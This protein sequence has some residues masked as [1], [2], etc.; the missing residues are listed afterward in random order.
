MA[1][2]RERYEPTARLAAMASGVDPDIFVRQITQESGW[3]SEVIHCARSSSAGAMGIAQIVPRFHP[4]VNPCSPE[5]ALAYAAGLMRSHLAV[6]DGDYALALSAYNAGPGATASGVKGQLPGWPYAETVNYVSSILNIS[7]DEAR[8]RLTGGSAVPT[9]LPYNP[10]APID[11]QPND[12]SCALQS[13][14]FLLRSIGRAPDASNPTTDPWLTSQLVPGIISPAV[15]LKD[16]TGHPLA[17]WITREYGSEMGFTAH[18]VDVTFDDVA[19]GAGVNPTIMGGRAYNHW[20]GVRR[21]NPD[22]T[23]ALANPA[24]GFKGITDSMSRAQFDALGPFSAVYIDRMP[25]APAP[26][27]P[28]PPSRVTVLVGEIRERLDELERIAS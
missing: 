8:R 11:I 24:P 14:Q 3:L 26:P 5:D 1:S 13:T 20:V 25:A 18:A 4:N 23:L 16:A 15:G 6:W 27:V 17:A 19:A 2:E 7:Q 9:A 22:G 10:D 28:V 21:V 12:W